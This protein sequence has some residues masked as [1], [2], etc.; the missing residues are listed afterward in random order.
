MGDIDSLANEKRGVLF[1]DDEEKSLKYFER[2]YGV[3]FKVYT[4]RTA[5]LATEVLEIH[6]EEIAI[7]ITDKRMPKV[8]GL[9]LISDVRKKNPEITRLLT[10]AYHDAEDII[11]AVNEGEIYRYIPKPWD[12]EELRADL[13]AAVKFYNAK[14]NDLKTKMRMNKSFLLA[15]ISTELQAPLQKIS[16]C[17]QAL[18]RKLPSLLDSMNNSTFWKETSGELPHELLAMLELPENIEFSLK[19]IH[20]FMD[21]LLAN[22]TFND[23]DQLDSGMC[24]ASDCIVD[25]IQLYPI[26]AFYAHRIHLKVQEDFYFRGSDEL[27]IL[28]MFNLLRNA[29]SSL[30]DANKGE[31]VINVTEGDIYNSIHVRDTG[32]GISEADMAHIFDAY[33]TTRSPG[34]GLG[35][36]LAFCKTV[37]E[38]MGGMISCDALD[39]EYC[40]IVINL[41]KLTDKYRKVRVE[42]KHVH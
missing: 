41:P 35:L 36:G 28:V 16:V 17:L 18:R 24:S 5:A 15:H 37:I 42:S 7:L 26:N 29:L 31:V 6:G 39:G 22:V 3:D 23:I 30:N 12:L 8:D 13:N 34:Y 2:A 33:F 25:A 14:S 19:E 20:V 27:M 32:S 4:A 21:T 10:T 11:R 1:V 38:G 9:Q 40:E